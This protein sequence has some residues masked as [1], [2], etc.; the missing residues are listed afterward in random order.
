MKKLLLLT[1][2][3]AGSFLFSQVNK[4]VNPKYLK[5]VLPSRPVM[6]ESK[7]TN[8]VKNQAARFVPQKKQATCSPVLFTFGPNAFGVGG[9]VNTYKQN[10]LTYNKDL[11]TVLWTNRASPL[12]GFSGFTS[13][14][15]Q[16]TWLNVAS[17]TWDSMIVYRDSTNIHAGR[18]PGGVFFNTS[19]NTN[20]ANAY[21]VGT[22]PTLASGNTWDGTFY[23]SRQI[24]GNYHKV[25]ASLDDNNV[26][27]NGTA[28]F[29]TQSSQVSNS[30]GY[31]FLSSDIQQ[32][33]N[34]V[35]V[36][37]GLGDLTYTVSN[38][39]SQYG[40]TIGKA[41]NLAWSHDT[42]VPGLYFNS[43]TGYA[44]D[45]EGMRIAFSPNGQI[46]YAV[47]IGRLSTAF[48][49]SSDSTLSPIVYKTTNGGTSWSP[50]SILPGFD[51]SL[52]HPELFKNV[53]KVFRNHPARQFKFYVNHG[54]DLTVDSL[55]TLHLVGT[56]TDPYLGSG[57]NLTVDSLMYGLTYQWDYINAH[58]IIWDLMTDGT[59]WNTILVD[60]LMSGEL[61]ADPASDTTAAYNPWGIGVTF[62]PYGAH[63][64]V[65]RS[66]TGGKIFYSWA[67]SDPMM[68]GTL[69][70]TNPDIHMK[71][72]D[73]SNQ[74]VTPSTNVTQ[75]LA[76]CYFHFLS[77]E[78]YYDNVQN[79]WVCPLVY[80]MPHSIT[81]PFNGS[82]TVDYH[83]VNCAVFTNSQYTDSASVYRTMGG[84]GIANHNSIVNSVVQNY[85][86]PFSQTTTITVNLKQSKS[87]DLKVFDVIGN[88]VYTKNANGNT[89][90]NN[91]VFD[92]SSLQ[93]GVYYYTITAGNERVTKKMILQK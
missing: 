75:G 93:A 84:V 50:S 89:G 8:P 90:E 92:G 10:C 28:P 56:M 49:N 59:N 53:G 16:S 78:S 40:G 91:F 64:Q 18:Y 62:M 20:I 17:N 3:T 31:A 79:G 44:S 34:T 61:A 76:E 60:S 80:T 26:C 43:N 11:N 6:D 81:S 21:V 39:Y 74:M 38:S 83:Y 70:N 1:F 14:A 58:P 67:D 47:F 15:I 77:N 55:G 2:L 35:F 9:D 68:T 7:K 32:A 25:D 29:G 51:W 71:S 54:M 12:W 46:G 48:G 86:N 65:I 45:N 66:A 5:A 72:Y 52:G 87:L 41:T 4:N 85:P 36:S 24:N 19:G 13:G 22:G 82:D 42:I 37:G 33:G 88:L 73:V 23:S 27:L 57:T 69:H 30:Y 63:I